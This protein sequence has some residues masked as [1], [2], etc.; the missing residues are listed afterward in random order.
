[1]RS[2][3]IGILVLILAGCATGK[4]VSDLAPGM[5]KAEVV[6][7]LGN[8]DGFRSEGDYEVL[9]YTNRMMSGWSWDRTDY[10]VVLLQGTVVE[11]GHGYIRR[12]DGPNPWV[13][14]HVSDRLLYD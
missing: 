3:L 14:L 12:D 5:T 1:M 13:L 10:I 9:E 6:D 4:S 8:P 2:V 7:Q 11:Y